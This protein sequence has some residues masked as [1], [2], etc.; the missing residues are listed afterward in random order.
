MMRKSSRFLSLSGLSGIF[1]GVY[2]IAGYF[3]AVWYINNVTVP[4]EELFTIK[5]NWFYLTDAMLVL[6]LSLLT[7]F[8]FSTRKAKRNNQKLFDHTAWNL[9]WQML[10]PL[11][12]GG[13]F[14]L[15]LFFNGEVWY[16]A[17]VMLC[18][19][20]CALFSASKYTYDDI[21][22]LGI[23]EIILGIIA[24]FDTG[25]GLIYWVIGFGILHILYGSLVWWK[26]ERIKN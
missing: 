11:A 13:L 10:I 4:R 24:S 9:L 26:Y 19:Y 15:A 21:K 16:L 3:A 22:Y 20:G 8:L 5:G 1:A 14:C 23:G 17:S 7:A 6:L 18:F 25:R 2:A 12:T